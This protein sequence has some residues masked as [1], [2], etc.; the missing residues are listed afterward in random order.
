MAV[1]EISMDSHRLQSALNEANLAVWLSD[2]AHWRPIPVAL[3]PVVVSRDAWTQIV[4]DARTLLGCFP[5]L[6]K[7]LQK[8]QQ[9]KLFDLLFY[10]L[11]P[12]EKMAAR[13][14]PDETWGHVTLRFDLYWHH[15]ELKI[16]ETNCTIPAMQ[17]YSD[18]VTSCWKRA[19]QRSDYHMT[20]FENSNDLLAS[21]T[22]KYREFGGGLPFPSIGIL[23]RPGDSQRREL[24][25]YCD[26]WSQ[27]GHRVVM[28]TPDDLAFDGRVWRSRDQTMDVIYRHIFGWRLDGHKSFSDWLT[29]SREVKLF[30]PLSAHYEVKGFLALLSMVSRNEAIASQVGMTPQ[31][32]SVILSRVPE[33]DVIWPDRLKEMYSNYFVRNIL[34]LSDQTVGDYVLKSNY[35]YGGH[36]VIMGDTWYDAATQDKLKG[37]MKVPSTISVSDGVRWM[38]STKDSLWIV[39]QRMSGRIHRTA[40]VTPDAVTEEQ[41]VY[42][43]ASVFLNSGPQTLC[44][45]GVSRFAT[46]QVVNIGTGGGLAPFA[47]SR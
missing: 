4:E 33:T 37:L 35:G 22:A 45:G 8:P 12:V 19:A 43:D 27:A 5:K 31:E 2:R 18:I 46:N 39:Q 14:P 29:R 30:N 6:L 36:Q 17:A 32:Q 24:E 25:H 40:I 1:V 21:L 9:D 28:V 15:G 13:C 44:G 38:Q 42:V 41:D 3:S 10:E 11:S 26:V 20:F 23:A 47:I 16:I 7:W 34:D